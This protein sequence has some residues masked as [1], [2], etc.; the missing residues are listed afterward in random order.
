MTVLD[1]YFDFVS[2]FAYLQWRRRGELPQGV[3]LRPRPVLFAGLLAHWGTVGPAEVAPKRAFTYRYVQWRARREGIALR[4]P[5][6]HP[7]N[8]LPALRL[9]LALDSDAAAIDT[10][11]TAVWGEG[12][13]PDD[14]R[15]LATRGAR[16]GVAD[17]DTAIARPTVKQALRSNTETA[18]ARGVFG[19][20]TLAIGD[21]LFWGEDATGMAS[22]WLADP[23][24]FED[25][26]MRRVSNLPVGVERR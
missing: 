14:P 10:I 6:A 22:D 7:F 16:L 11:F 19:V 26:E 3:E 1:W 8:P 21:T 15:V 24:A 9:A 17:V 13:R 23:E 25:A 5:D 18:I 12:R 4:M 2:P 20:P